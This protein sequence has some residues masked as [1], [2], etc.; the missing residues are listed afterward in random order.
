MLP[1]ESMEKQVTVATPTDKII[2]AKVSGLPQLN[3]CYNCE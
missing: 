3:F 2:L 1:V